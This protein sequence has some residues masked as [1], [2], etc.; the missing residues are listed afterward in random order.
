[1]GKRKIVLLRRLKNMEQY[2]RSLHVP[3]DKTAADKFID[4]IVGQRYRTL[5]ENGILTITRRLSLKK[6]KKRL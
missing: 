6:K 4:A 3:M 5:F 1:M 2:G